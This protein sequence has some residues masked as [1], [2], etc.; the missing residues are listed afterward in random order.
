MVNK[1]EV[2]GSQVR[3]CQCLHAKEVVVATE[4]DVGETSRVEAST[5]NMEE[6]TCALEKEFAAFKKGVCADLKQLVGSTK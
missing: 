5:K 4:R 2:F 3:E 1:F 6:A